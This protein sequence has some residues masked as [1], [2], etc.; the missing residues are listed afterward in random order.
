LYLDIQRTRFRDRLEV[1][2]EVDADVLDAYVPGM[3]LQPLVENALTHGIAPK[4]AGG[5][6][7]ITAARGGDA[8]VVLRVADDGV[9]LP[10]G[11]TR[12]R[13]GV[14]NTRGRLRALYGDA[15]SFTLAPLPGGGT[16]SEVRVPFRAAPTRTSEF[17]VGAVAGQPHAAASSRPAAEPVAVA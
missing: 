12:E 5:T 13:T 8:T 16:V 14:G 7:R 9:G 4:V 11:G 15:H 10:A 6:L 3:V 2:V 1:K 17:P